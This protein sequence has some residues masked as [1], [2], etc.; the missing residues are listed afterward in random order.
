V[1]TDAQAVALS[2]LGCHEAQ[3][4]YYGKPM[5]SADFQVWLNDRKK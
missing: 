4:Y 3:G 1:E 2:K 5:T